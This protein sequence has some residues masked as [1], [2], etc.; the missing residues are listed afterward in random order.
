MQMRGVVGSE[1]GSLRCTAKY[2]I[3]I[4]DFEDSRGLDL[5]EM[6][7]TLDST[8][9]ILIRICKKVVRHTIPI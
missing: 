3:S 7:I 4:D 8:A 5:M 1:H 6:A 2:T 9:D